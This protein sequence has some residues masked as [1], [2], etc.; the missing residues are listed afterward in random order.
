M[1]DDTMEEPQKAPL[2]MPSPPESVS[3][4]AIAERRLLE[5]KSLEEAIVWTQIRGEIQKQDR[6]QQEFQH[7]EK[8][9]RQRE[10]LDLIRQL[11]FLG[12]GIGLIVGGHSWIGGFLAAAAAYPMAKEFVMEKFPKISLPGGGRQ[13]ES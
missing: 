13:D 3:G 6:L 11:A 12:A 8:R 4:V 5:A 9:S 1:S 2:P 7:S 10:I